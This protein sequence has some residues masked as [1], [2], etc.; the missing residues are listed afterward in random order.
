MNQDTQKTFALKLFGLSIIAG[1]IW[2]TAIGPQVTKV[3]DAAELHQQQ[4]DEIRTG[5]D[6]ISRQ[7]DAVQTSI[8]KMTKIRNEISS[9]FSV[10]QTANWHKDLQESAEKF[11]LTV[12]RIE[13]LRN[14]VA[15]RESELEQGT[16]QLGTSEFRIESLGSY[17]GIVKY[18]ESLSNG[19]NIARVNSFRITPV[20]KEY[21][22]LMLQVSIYQITEVPEVFTDSFVE[23]EA[24]ITEVGA[25]D[26]ET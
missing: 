1:G 21:A 6:S 13:P 7:A 14:A 26:G 22:R 4:L 17:D 18:L 25:T 23:P 2:H 10:H 24:S 8:S 5:E 19:A 11:G 3:G 20:S 15:N 12:S 16:I 9:Q